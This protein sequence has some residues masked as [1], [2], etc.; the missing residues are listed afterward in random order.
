M[1]L[2][3]AGP[4]LVPGIEVRYGKIKGKIFR[5]AGAWLYIDASWRHRNREHGGAI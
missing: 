4:D 5:L 3:E 1:L 2:T